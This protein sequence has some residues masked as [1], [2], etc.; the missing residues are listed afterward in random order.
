MATMQQHLENTLTL[1]QN[2]NLDPV[3]KRKLTKKLKSQVRDVYGFEALANMDMVLKMVKK[4]NWVLTPELLPQ[5]LEL[6]KQI[7]NTIDADS[8]MA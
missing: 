3:Q 5:L 7:Q 4:N 1:C 2:P 6:A 8:Q